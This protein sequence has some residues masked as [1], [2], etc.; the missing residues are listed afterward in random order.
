MRSVLILILL[1]FGMQAFAQQG[2]QMDFG[3][4]DSS[5]VLLQRQV[6]YYNFINGG[7]NVNPLQPELQLPEF[8]LEHVYHSRYTLSINM[9][10]QFNSTSFSLRSTDFISPFFYNAEMLSSAAYQLGDKF[11]IGGFSYGANSVLSAPLPNQNSSYFDAYGSTM[12]MQ[13]KVSKKFKIETSISIQ[14]NRQGPPGF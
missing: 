4:V 12:F 5:E 3:E 7:L 6:E 8:N 13:Y 1:F 9:F 10:P 2:L 14:Q 11:M